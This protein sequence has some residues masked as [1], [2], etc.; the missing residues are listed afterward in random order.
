MHPGCFV[1]TPTPPISGRRTPRPDP[2]RVCLCVLFLV[3]LGGP[4]SRAGFGAPHLSQGHSVPLLCSAP[5]GLALPVLRV[6][7]SFLSPPPLSRP[8]CL[9]LFVLPS[10]RCPG[11]WR[12]LFAP[13]ASPPPC[14]PFFCLPAFLALWRP[15]PLRCGG[16]L[17]PAFGA[18]SLG[19]AQLH[20]PLFFPSPLPLL[21]SCLCVSVLFCFVFPAPPCLVFSV[22]SGP[23]CP[24]P[25]RL[26]AAP[27]PPALSLSLCV[28]L[29][30]FPFPFFSLFF[31]RSGL[32]LVPAALG[33]L[34]F[35]TF[36]L[37]FFFLLRV[38]PCVWCVRCVLGLRPPPSGGCS[39]P[40]VS[41]VLL[42]F[43]ATV[44]CLLVCVVRGSLR[45]FS[46]PC[47]AG[48]VLCGVVTC[49]VISFV[50]GGLP[51]ALLPSFA[52]VLCGAL[53]CRAVFCGALSCVVPSGVAVRCVVR[54]VVLVSGVVWSSG[55]LLCVEFSCPA[56]PP[57]CC[58]LLP[59]PGPLS[60]P[61]VV[62]CPGVWCCVVLLCRL[63]CGVL[64]SVSFLA[65]GALF[66]RLHWLVP[67]CCLWL[68]GVRCW[69][70][71]PAVSLP[72]CALSQVFLPCCVVCCPAV[73]CGLL[74]RAAPLRC[75]L[76]SAVLPCRVV[77]CCGAL[78][79]VFLCWWCWFV[80]FPCVCGAVLRCLS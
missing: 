25:Q 69:V 63:S 57:C 42:L 74:W 2:A 7:F 1:S 50:D 3:G 17:F 77:P 60:W 66:L 39:R 12:S 52:L 59:L 64:V 36:W 71:L 55:P 79:S 38:R 47:G 61:V 32:F 22:V 68:L 29:F 24:G 45:C 26:V 14:F 19:V 76:S 16:L 78:L 40:A 70:W 73:G 15:A 44:C 21:P 54:C 10:P 8:R 58:P 13:A 67:C 75:V 6:F 5:S 48:V 30:F 65:G 20:P 41:G 53:L 80:S 56:P 9:R 37:G 28:C 72:W 4:A 49:F 34:G 31:C 46:V 11:P 51:W 43:G 35:C 18:P 33:A 27:P 23:G 62:V